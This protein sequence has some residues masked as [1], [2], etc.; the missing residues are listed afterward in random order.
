MV[1]LESPPSPLLLPNAPLACNGDLV[2]RNLCDASRLLIPPV[3]KAASIFD[4][5]EVGRA[6]ADT[7]SAVPAPAACK[8]GSV[9]GFQGQKRKWVVGG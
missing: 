6:C 3:V 9:E 8:S 5:A 1:P 4:D 2:V 7:F